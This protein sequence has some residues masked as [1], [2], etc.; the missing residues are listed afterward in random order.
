[1]LESKA[2]LQLISSEDSS[3]IVMQYEESEMQKSKIMIFIPT[4]LF[5]P[6]KI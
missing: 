6:P 2:R 4:V 1:M 5:F 3:T